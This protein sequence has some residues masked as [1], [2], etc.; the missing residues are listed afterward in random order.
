MRAAA[1]A[2]LVLPAIFLAAV[3]DAEG[4]DRPCRLWIRGDVYY[5]MTYNGFPR[6]N[7]DNTLYPGDAFWYEFKWGFPGYCHGERVHAPRVHGYAI[8][9]EGGE[10]IIQEYNEKVSGRCGDAQAAGSRQNSCRPH[11]YP[12]YTTVTHGPAEIVISGANDCLGAGNNG[13]AGYGDYE[14]WLRLTGTC[15]SIQMT[16]SAQETHCSKIRCHTFTKTRTATITPVI[17]APAVEAHLYEQM[18]L[19]S[20]GYI[21]ANP[22]MTNYVYDP[23][24]IEH[25]TRFDYRNERN[26]TIT[27]HYTREFAPL[28]Q[29]GG[30]ECDER[31]TVWLRPSWDSAGTGF[32]P[33]RFECGNGDGVY[34]YAATSHDHLGDRDI[35]YSVRVENI[36]RMVNNGY[37]ST[38]QLIVAHD[39]VYEVYPYGVLSDLQSHAYDNRHGVMVKYLGSMGTGRDDN[40]ILNQD[41]RS[42]INAFYPNTTLW[43][44]GQYPRIQIPESGI[45]WDSAPQIPG[46]NPPDWR[47]HF[48]RWF[49]HN[50]EA[51]IPDTGP[52]PYMSHGRHAMFEYDGYGV[53]RFE[54]PLTDIVFD[55]DNAERFYE[56]VTVHNRVAVENWAGYDSYVNYDYVYQYP[57]ATFAAWYNMTAYTNDRS[58]ST[59]PLNATETILGIPIDRNGDMVLKDDNITIM[60]D[61]YVYAKTLHDTGDRWFAQWA[62][63]EV[64]DMENDGYGIGTLAI[65]LKKTV[66]EFAPGYSFDRPGQNILDAPKYDAFEFGAPTTISMSTPTH[67]V[68]RLFVTEFMHPHHEEFVSSTSYK[69]VNMTRIRDGNIMT[70]STD[71][72]W[73]NT[74]YVI[75]GGD[76]YLF[77]G[78]CSSG[79]IL[80]M[81]HGGDIHVENEWGSKM[82]ATVL[83]EESFEA[84]P[85]IEDN[86]ESMLPYMTYVGFMAL[87]IFVVLLFT[88]KMIRN[89]ISTG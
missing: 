50:P 52:R 75:N 85:A 6:N 61:E 21:A 18:I 58:V 66:L 47:P 40:G 14:S 17:R 39:P 80:A 72:W 13:S 64:Y 88:V 37:N 9:A 26:G 44:S 53:I 22:D 3:P 2:M 54:Q 35:K 42:K 29:E 33:H 63:H 65:W 51:I 24:T 62:L 69:E 36:G 1:L 82:N 48:A 89:A 30:F 73:G 87:I 19:D 20:D 77:E 5:N 74:K 76:R 25:V 23:V 56:N 15:G 84:P 60:L 70:F 79:C 10:D 46:A 7:P 34:A 31:D 28:N 27:F 71:H 12:S 78:D 68:D 49:E 41:R 81:I 8:L 16:I 67:T 32:M 11:A 55:R 83:Q 45:R 38:T 4:G 86:I 59:V 43:S 57:H